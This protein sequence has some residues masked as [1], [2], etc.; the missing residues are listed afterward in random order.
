[1]GD[2]IKTEDGEGEGELDNVGAEHK[3][4]CQAFGCVARDFQEGEDQRDEV[5]TDVGCF[6]AEGE[7]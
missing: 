7:S 6:P 5:E 1:M 2:N 3:E 4:G